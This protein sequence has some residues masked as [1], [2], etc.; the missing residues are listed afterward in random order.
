MATHKSSGRDF[1][2]AVYMDRAA[3]L[4]A[5]NIGLGDTLAEA[6]HEADELGARYISSGYAG[7]TYRRDNLNSPWVKA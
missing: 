7:R 6:K 5:D 4:N 2:W 1:R 3:W